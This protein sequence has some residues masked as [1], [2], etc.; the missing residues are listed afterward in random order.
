MRRQPG[1][2]GRPVFCSHP[3][4]ALPRTC[5]P[6]SL[7][8]VCLAPASLR[9]HQPGRHTHL[10][11]ASPAPCPVP[12]SPLPSSPLHTTRAPASCQEPQRQLWAGFWTGNL[13][14]GVISLFPGFLLPQTQCLAP[15]AGQTACTHQVLGCQGHLLPLPNP[16]LCPTSGRP[17]FD[18]QP[19]LT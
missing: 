11:P 14:V 12:L 15:A 9:L 10:S 18:P 8:P 4:P 17:L 5:R 13:P 19:N 16:S 1:P 6:P 7:P 3:T 2:G